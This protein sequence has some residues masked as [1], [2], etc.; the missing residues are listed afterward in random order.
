MSSRMRFALKQIEKIYSDNDFAGGVILVSEDEG[1]M[2]ARLDCAWNGISNDGNLIALGFKKG[3]SRKIAATK[4]F[5]GILAHVTEHWHNGA[6]MMLDILEKHVE[7]VNPDD[8][9]DDKLPNAEMA[10]E[11]LSNLIPLRKK[12]TPN[13][14]S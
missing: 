10:K 12:G 13:D 6:R 2:F 8:V 5:A 9:P 4:H 11:F 7:R 1:T 3:E 14:K